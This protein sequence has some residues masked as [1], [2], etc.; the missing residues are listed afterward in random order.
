MKQKKMI[1]TSKDVKIMF[2]TNLIN[3]QHIAINSKNADDFK[4]QLLKGLDLKGDIPLSPEKENLKRLIM[5]DGMTIKEASTEREMKLET[6]TYLWN[7][8]TNKGNIEDFSPD[9]LFDTYK[10][11]EG[12][13]SSQSILPDKSQMIKWMKRWDTGTDSK[14]IEIRKENKQRII[15]R[16]IERIEK[17]NYE[18]SR[19]AFPPG[20]SF[21]EK[22]EMIK[23]WW[24]D[25]RFHLSMAARSW[26]ELNQLMGNTLSDDMKA[27]YQTAQKK[28]IPVFV[29]PY[30]LSLM[31]VTEKNYDDAALRSYVFYSQNLV[32][33]FGNIKAWEKE[34]QVETDKP[35][36]AGWLLPEGHNIHR[37]YPEVA[38][39]IPDTI[40]RACGGL[41]ASCQRLYD[42]QSG[43]FNFD[44]EALIPKQAWDSKLKLL[45]KYFLED[46][47]LR[48]ILITGGDALMSR[49]N[50]L[51]KIL[52]AVYVMAKQK[53]HDNMKRP[54]GEK[55]AEIQR[56]RLGTRLPVY[57]P[58]RINDELITI[59]SEFK[60]KAVKIGITQFFI[61]THFQ[62]PLEITLEVRDGIRKLNAAGWT[63]T[64]QLVYNVAASRRGHSAKL[65]RELNKIGVLCYYTFSVKGFDENHA[66][67]TPNSRSLQEQQEEKMFGQLNAA[68]A[69]EL[70]EYLNNNCS[71]EKSISQ[72]EKKYDLPFLATDR[73]VMNLPGIGKSMTFNLV[74]I[75]P[76]GCRILAFTHDNTRRH[77]PVI[78]D[79]PI[80]YIKENKSLAEYIRQLSDMGEKVSDYS[81]LWKYTSGKTEPRFAFY[82]YP[83]PA[84]E[85]TTEYSNIAQ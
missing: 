11:F 12:L 26:R 33:T 54:S 41:C 55:Y 84:E 39:L 42:F 24:F 76:D 4:K 3:I 65:R 85:Y 10:Q 29:T 70:I 47:Q 17:H 79:I 28:G 46:K 80:V 61:Q 73:N 13:T 68:G 31:D 21:I 71:Q 57:L 6:I 25:Y 37:R 22:Q 63:V 49:N 82:E 51:K 30:Y 1:L 74:A 44:M 78:K 35:N 43:R 5:H 7:F 58:M 62:T 14:I 75:M 36:A 32:D 81:S 45:M 19:Y 83:K 16:L 27:I 20:I 15:N 34:D 52:D 60:E 77:S 38:I 66:V 72:I 9:F 40:G 8:L 48:D 56:V 23:E 2:E 67:F 53:Q 69:S 59:L 64:N 50:S 18:K